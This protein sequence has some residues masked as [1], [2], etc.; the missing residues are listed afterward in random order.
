MPDKSKAGITW[1]NVTI[2][3]MIYLIIF[4]NACLNVFNADFFAVEPSAWERDVEAL[5]LFYENSGNNKTVVKEFIGYFHTKY[6]D[7]GYNIIEINFSDNFYCYIDKEMVNKL[8]LISK[9]STKHIGKE[10]NVEINFVLASENRRN[11]T[12]V[13][14]ILSIIFNILIIFLFYKSIKND[15]KKF[16][17]NPL[18]LIVKTIN[19][20]MYEP[21]NEYCNILYLNPKKR[22]KSNISMTKNTRLL[23]LV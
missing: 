17:L 2:R 16:I 14:R 23:L 21:L 22:G 20:L 1:M 4:L 11:L 18:N 3:R 7:V 5:S 10:K 8:R 9:I 6:K 19:T 15:S 13:F 12:I